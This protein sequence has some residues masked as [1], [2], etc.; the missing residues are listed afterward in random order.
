MRV[1]EVGA[2]VGLPGIVA[3]RAGAMVTLTDRDDAK[4]LLREILY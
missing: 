2:G 1:L 3:A 4:V